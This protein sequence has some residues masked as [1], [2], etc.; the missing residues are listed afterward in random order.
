MEDAY[1]HCEALVRERDRA[2][3]LSALFAPAKKRKHLFALYA[4]DLE[5]SHVPDAVREPMA[6]EIRLQWWRDVLAGER[7]GEAKANP[8]AAALL[9]TVERYAVSAEAMHRSIDA[10]EFDLIGSPMASQTALDAY[11][12]D[13][14]GVTMA[15]AA[16]I[17]A[18]GS[19]LGEA[20]RVG[21]RAWGMI[22]L[23][24]N[25]GRDV[26]R[27]RLF[28][29]LDLLARHE[30]HTASVFAAET[31]TGLH[32]AIAELCA[33]AEKDHRSLREAKVPQAAVPAFLI[34]ALVPASAA[35]IRRVSD[36]FREPM[37]LSAI[38]SQFLL[39]R[40]ARRGSV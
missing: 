20:S 34:A 3:F 24:Q 29:P 40:A 25:V 8:V 31:S 26:A 10:R 28:L 4:F 27:G 2:R 17:L 12:D 38:R 1:Q 18:P 36:P 19:D 6:G 37:E 14:S 39:W 11:L 7:A 13:T 16:T 35:R 32:G 9:D 23:L 21:G 15:A 22:K 33:N 5:L 30:V